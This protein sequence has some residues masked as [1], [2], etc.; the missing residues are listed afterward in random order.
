MFVFG[1]IGYFMSLANLD[2]SL[3][4]LGLILGPVLEENIRRAM[5][6]ARGDV[7]VFATRPI[8]AGFLIVGVIVLVTA[9]VWRHKRQT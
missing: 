8:S 9:L 4:F 1:A 6:I 7:T 3:L 5:L 2:R